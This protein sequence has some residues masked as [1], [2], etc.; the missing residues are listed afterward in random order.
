MPE[1]PASLWK[2]WTPMWLNMSDRWRQTLQVVT[3]AADSRPH[4]VVFGAMLNLA[5][6]PYI[7][8]GQVRRSNES[9]RRYD[10]RAVHAAV[11]WFVTAAATRELLARKRLQVVLIH[12]LAE[13]VPSNVYRGVRLH[14]LSTPIST[15]AGWPIPAQDARWAGYL[16]A[17]QS[18]APIAAAACTFAVDFSD[19]RVLNDLRRPCEL[20]SARS[21]FVSTDTCHGMS[22][23]LG[24]VQRQVEDAGFRASPQ[25]QS[26]IASMQQPETLSEPQ[27]I[28]NCAVVGGRFASVF[29][30][31]IRTL[32]DRTREHY[33]RQALPH[34]ALPPN[35]ID[36]A[37]VND[38]I[39]QWSP[40]RV[41]R[42]WPFGPVNAPFWGEVCRSEGHFCSVGGYRHNPMAL[43]DLRRRIHEHSRTNGYLPAPNVTAF[44]HRP[45]GVRDMLAD[46]QTR[47]YFAH[48]LGCG[49][50]IRC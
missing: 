40:A 15:S 42:G 37:L 29:A 25:L 13:V 23:G 12:D 41:V 35:V 3:P 4:A 48:K 16:D 1:K 33:E 27:I 34:G 31:L 10:L 28:L 18:S 26:A 8:N 32:A 36:M 14:K 44:A 30:P 50:S 49:R 46:M 38:V 2:R 39:A 7:A 19:V 43:A 21:V 11:D 20:H 22:T 9:T 47:M 6:S 5:T 17:M 45:C 24:L